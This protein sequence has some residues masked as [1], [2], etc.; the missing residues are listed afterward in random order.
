MPMLTVT[1]KIFKIATTEFQTSFGDRMCN[2][3]KCS[4]NR[5]A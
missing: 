1:S 5:D 3:P 2:W 4:S